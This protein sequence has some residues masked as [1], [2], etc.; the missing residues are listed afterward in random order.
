MSAKNKTDLTDAEIID[1]YQRH[2]SSRRA[3]DELGCNAS[4]VERR[5]HK[6]N[7]PMGR[8]IY[9]TSTLVRGGEGD[10]FALQWVKEKAAQPT[11][12][13]I[14]EGLKDALRSTKPLPR[15]KAPKKVFADLLAVYP[16][17]D[18]HFGQYSWSEE[19]GDDYDLRIAEELH[20]GAMDR[21]VASAPAAENALI[22]NVGDYFHAN[23]GKNRTPQS[24]HAL[25]V[26]TRH[27]KVVTA[28][29]RS[30]RRMIERALEVHKTVKL[31]SVPGNH[32][33]ESSIVLSIALG[34][35]YENNPRVIIDDSP[36][37][38]VYHRH[39]KCLI[40]VTHGD[41]CKIERLGELMA[42]DRRKEWGETDYHHWFT[43][44]LHHRRFHE[45][46]GFTVEVLRTLAGKDAYAA[47]HNYR[48]ERDMQVV[49]FDK[50]HGEQE[51]HTVN[52][53]QVR[54]A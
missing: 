11:K 35:L 41:T 24:Q 48:S 49:V 2:G 25:D 5:L 36:A 23:D 9:A 39:G 33:I 44:H 30:L 45:G 1:A 50:T 43:G 16:M 31:I 40:G 18:P 34:M 4:T 42:C 13:Q 51:R 14:L 46:V 19:T 32:D 27:R 29:V 3:A 8:Q 54:A 37:K 15:V 53:R 38:F 12:A 22:V 21:L 7:I 6:N 26:D 28:G 10:S 47:S 52:A 20:V 17:G